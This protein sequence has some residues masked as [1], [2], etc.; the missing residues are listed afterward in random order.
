MKLKFLGQPHDEVLMMTDS[1]YKNYK[2]KEDR[3]ILKGGLLF[4]KKIGETGSI[5]YYQFLIPKQ[6]VI[7]VRRSLHGEFG[8]HPRICKTIIAYREKW[9]FPK[10][11]QLIKERVMSSEQIIKEFRIDR[12]VNRLLL[13]N[14]NQHITAPED[15]MQIDLVPELPL[16]VG[17]ENI[18]TAMD[19]FSRYSFA[20]PTSNQDAKTIAK[21]LISTMTK[22]AYLPTTLI[23]DKGTAFM[24]HVIEK[25]AG[26]LGITLKHANTRDDQ[27]IGLLER[28][29]A[30]I[31][32]A[33]KI[34]TGEW[35]SLW[36]KYVNIA[37]L[38]YNTSYHTII[39]CKPSRVFH[40]G[41]HYKI[42]NLKLGIRPQQQPIP[43]SQIAQDVLDQTEMLHQDVRKKAMQAYIKYQT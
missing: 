22:H 5:K 15:A 29:H 20:H 40:G 30:S 18:V 25:V 7:E 11:E 35:R 17:Y 32:Q 42:L 19:V 8:K 27:T 3:I 23:S 14:T 33:L 39:G 36:H 37:V 16:S 31:K 2:A 12:S 21:V 10:T 28:S 6:L 41:I 1:R 24:S 4:R 9:Y 43:T 26:V 13:Q 38:N 34:E